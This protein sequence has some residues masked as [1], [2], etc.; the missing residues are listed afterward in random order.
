[1]NDS[2][3]LN[4]EEDVDFL[5][6]AFNDLK[7]RKGFLEMCS[8]LKALAQ[9]GTDVTQIYTI[10]EKTNIKDFVKFISDFRRIPNKYL[11]ELSDKIGNKKS[12]PMIGIAGVMNTFESKN[13]LMVRFRDNTCKIGKTYEEQWQN[14]IQ[15]NPLCGAL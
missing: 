3:K 11:V 12:T 6:S 14:L 4:L 8:L 1:M 9:E 7:I 2:N 10:L 5:C 15:T 13:S